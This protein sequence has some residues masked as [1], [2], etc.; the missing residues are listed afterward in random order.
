MLSFGKG[1]GL[2]VRIVLIVIDR[3]ADVVLPLIDLLIFLR[4]QVAP[5]RR[6]I[7]R[8][9]TIYAASRPST[10]RVSPAVIWPERTTWAMRCS[11]FST[12]TPGRKKGAFCGPPP[13]TEAKLLRSA[14]A[15]CT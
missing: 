13:F 7:I 12:R 14:C 10:F 2:R 5:V 11:W 9:L 15:I 8:N 4:G 1:L 3:A 6:A